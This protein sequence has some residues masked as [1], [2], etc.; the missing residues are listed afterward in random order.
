MSNTTICRANIIAQSIVQ[1][2]L[3]AT[4]IAGTTSDVPLTNPGVQP[5]D[6]IQAAFDAAL[7][8]GISIG[9]AYSNAANT[10]VVRLVNS[11]GASATQTAAHIGEDNLGAAVHS[12]LLGVPFVGIP[13][14]RALSEA[15][16]L[17]DSASERKVELLNTPI[18][19]SFAK[20]IPDKRAGKRF[21]TRRHKIYKWKR[22][23]R[24]KS[25]KF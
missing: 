18:I 7:V 11:T 13:S 3:P 17:I 4:T 9:N 8:T 1:A 23:R 16:K 6:F 5:N 10:V 20:Y 24:T 19:G 12:L 22:T 14:Q 21:S 15:E 25:A 2:T